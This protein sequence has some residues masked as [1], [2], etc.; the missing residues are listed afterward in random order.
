MVSRRAKLRILLC[1]L[2]AAVVLVAAF[3]LLRSKAPHEF[4]ELSNA[5]VLVGDLTATT[6]F[7]PPT[8]CRLVGAHGES[9]WD[10]TDFKSWAVWVPTEVE[11]EPLILA[12]W[13]STNTVAWSDPESLDRAVTLAATGANVRRL[14]RPMHKTLIGNFDSKMGGAW[15]VGVLSYENGSLLI[16]EWIRR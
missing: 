4:A 3:I 12:R 2:C 15:K 5:V 14:A 11:A 6:G 7:A 1:A 16:F 8:G 13:P 9:A 10:G